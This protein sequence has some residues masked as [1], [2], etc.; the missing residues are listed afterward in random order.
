ML[1]R[2]AVL[3]AGDFKDPRIDPLLDRAWQ[4]MLDCRDHRGAAAVL[5]QAMITAQS[6]A[7][8]VRLAV[9]AEWGT[10][11]TPPFLPS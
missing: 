1:L 6:R 8:L 10:G 2:A 3:H 11:S 4:G 5:G 9:V 7:G